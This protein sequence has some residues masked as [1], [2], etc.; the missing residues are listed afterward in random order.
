MTLYGGNNLARSRV[1]SSGLTWSPGQA[2]DELDIEYALQGI[3]IHLLLTNDRHPILLYTMIRLCGSI[4]PLC[5]QNFSKTLFLAI[6]AGRAGGS[7]LECIPP[8]STRSSRFYGNF[9]CS[10]CVGLCRHC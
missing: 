7:K 9:I 4:F 6:K 2:T 5:F 1:A 10:R 8:R 3:V